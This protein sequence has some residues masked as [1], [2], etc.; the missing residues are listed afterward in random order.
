MRRGSATPSGSILAATQRPGLLQLKAASV[1]VCGV[2]FALASGVA[3]PPQEA[4]ERPVPTEQSGVR[5]QV[6][7]PAPKLAEG[8]GRLRV[9]CLEGDATRAVRVVARHSQQGFLDG[10]GRGLYEDGRFFADG[11]FELIAEAGAVELELRSGPEFYPLSVTVQIAAGETLELVVDLRRWFS[12]RKRGWYGGDNH[13]HAQH[14]RHAAVRTDAA[15]AALQ[16]RAA[17]LHYLTEAGSHGGTRADTSLDR[18]HFL[19]R[20]AP[21]LRPGCFAGH[22]NT[23]GLSPVFTDEEMR[24]FSSQPLPVAAIVEEVGRRGGASIHTHT[25]TPPHQLHWMGAAELLPDAVLGQVADL[26]DVD[27]RASEEL[28]F[29]VLNLGVRAGVSSYTD[30]ALG[31]R[32]TRS[33]GDRRVY[34]RADTFSYREI[35]EALQRGRTFATNGGP[36]FLFFRI[37]NKLPGSTVTY[38]S[39]VSVRVETQSLHA[40]RSVE[41]LWRG[42]RWRSLDASGRRGKQVWELRMDAPPLESGPSR[43]VGRPGSVAAQSGGALEQGLEQP[44]RSEPPGWLVARAEDEAGHW[45]V[46]SPIYFGDPTSSGTGNEVEPG[47][48]GPPKASL[49]GGTPR[50]RSHSASDVRAHSVLFQISNATRFIELR[51]QFFAHMMVTIA[52]DALRRVELRRDGALV[53]AW[54]AT[55]PSFVAGG[56]LPVTELHGEYEAGWVW[57]PAD[58]PQHFQ[59]DWPVAESGWYAV[60]AVPS[61]GEPIVSESVFFDRESSVSHA[62]SAASLR[63]PGTQLRWW[64]F[65]AEM[66]LGEIE[67]PFE[68]DHWWFP[69]S[70][71]WRLET[72]FDGVP[73]RF[74][75]GEPT[76]AKRFRSRHELLPLRPL[77]PVRLF[78]GRNLEGLYTWLHGSR[79]GDPRGVFEARDGLLRISGEGFGYI[80]TRQAYRDYHLIVEYRWGSAPNWKERRGKARDAGIFLH[81]TGPDGNSHDGDGAFRASLECQVMEGA[82]GDLMLIRGTDGEGK[83]V[84]M[85][86]E[87]TV[88]PQNDRDGWP[89]WQAG[90]VRRTLKGWGRLNWR[91]KDPAWRDIVGFRG[92]QD[93]DSPT[94]EWTRLDIHCR[95][96]SV[97]VDV[98]GQ[99]VNHITQT[100]LNCGQV[101]LQCEGSEILIRRWEVLPLARD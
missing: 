11:E 68:G 67:V 49:P 80:G 73:R 4:A 31:R 7:Q 15:Y 3:L 85:G 56:K 32:R 65:G 34:C 79:Y 25:M 77:H 6:R 94:T 50:R 39:G 27:S 76:A 1:M 22:L 52:N 17:G 58:V 59:A 2:L 99:R 90:G 46:S 24:K 57:H 74:G 21:E 20:T 92:G 78:N 45:A 19:F 101:L 37:D 14:D 63:G 62:I 38:R 97:A 13:V 42:R 75:G 9:R 28:W 44:V 35:V 18:S 88:A 66:P 47:P 98:N 96:N 61:E 12:T 64:G 87:T 69:R 84:A 91:G 86:F 30:A 10:S 95:G 48:E 51:R 54:D 43:A 82:V 40:L 71:F 81:A 100:T 23:P 93:V 29:S 70:T 26:V 60:T 72:E 36:L 8:K 55:K 89:Y 33:P 16:A 5:E 41:L 53:K 83:P